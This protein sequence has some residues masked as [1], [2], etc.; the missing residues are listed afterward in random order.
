MINFDSER[1]EECWI[2]FAQLHQTPT[3]TP[4]LKIALYKYEIER[5]PNAVPNSSFPSCPSQTQW[6]KSLLLPVARVKK[7]ISFNPLILGELTLIINWETQIKLM[8]R[9]QEPV[10]IQ[11]YNRHK[12]SRKLHMIKPSPNSNSFCNI[13]E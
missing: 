5:N 9:D 7:S 3:T 11:T 4:V 1:E 2:K 8:V 12:S 6:L 13:H 10:K